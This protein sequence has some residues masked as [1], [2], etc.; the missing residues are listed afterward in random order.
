MVLFAHCANSSPSETKLKT[1]SSLV[2]L[3]AEGHWKRVGWMVLF[4]YE[5]IKEAVYFNFLL[6]TY[7]LILL[8]PCIFLYYFLN[9]TVLF[10]H[11]IINNNK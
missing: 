9:N 4:I 11:K 3:K 1:I 7:Y 2:D 5:E 6:H 10:F 8:I